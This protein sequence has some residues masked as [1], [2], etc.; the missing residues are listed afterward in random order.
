MVI[1]NEQSRASAIRIAQKAP[2]GTR[3]E[4]KAIRRSLPQNSRMWAMLSDLATQ[5]R[6]HGHKW[7]PEDWKEFFLAA[8]KQEL[9]FMPNINSDGF[10]MLG[11]SS[12]NLSKQEM[13]DLMTLMEMFGAQHNVT[14]SNP[15]EPSP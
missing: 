4:Y 5:V 2:Y 7:T 1:N 8:L 3:V 6:W 14:F 9:R 13:S 11:R 15:K 10:V 12:S